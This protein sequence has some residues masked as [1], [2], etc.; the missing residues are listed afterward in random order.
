MGLFSNLFGKKET[1]SARAERIA[2]T[3]KERTDK[4]L[5]GVSVERIAA[6]YRMTDKAV[7]IG[8][9]R[10]GVYQRTLNVDDKIKLLDE[11]I[12]G[13]D[14]RGEHLVSV[15]GTVAVAIAADE[16]H[17][18]VFTLES[19]RATQRLLAPAKLL[20]VELVVDDES[21]I[22]T[23]SSTKLGGAIVGGLL[24][25]GAGAIVGGLTGRDKQV[26]KK[27]VNKVEVRVT[28]DDLSFSSVRL[29]LLA[30]PVEASDKMFATIEGRAKNWIDW[31]TI[32]MRR[33]KV[34]T[35]SDN[36]ELRNVRRKASKPAKPKVVAE[37]NNIIAELTR[38]AEL[39]ASGALTAEEFDVLKHG[40]LAK[41]K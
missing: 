30:T 25:G 40:L 31:L 20:A 36:P 2:R 18:H 32:L 10:A 22:R 17:L 16:E 6:E 41:A 24:F 37:S 23:T 5:S 1:D 27:V 33:A 12:F 29:Q 35:E 8:L 34:R 26:Q 9:M 15:D 14:K 13:L 3:T 21:V 7:M 4:Y 39:K 19:S 11:A 28:I 38:L